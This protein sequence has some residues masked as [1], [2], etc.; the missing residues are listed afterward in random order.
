MFWRTHHTKPD[1][2]S[3]RVMRP[4]TRTRANTNQIGQNQCCGQRCKRLRCA[5]V[6]W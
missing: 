6:R 2:K 1:P 5:R 4:R 3:I